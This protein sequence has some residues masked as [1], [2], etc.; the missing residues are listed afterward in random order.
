M[1]LRWLVNQ[2]L[3]DA[4]EG[5]VREV[6]ADIAQSPRTG[7]RVPSPPVSAEAPTAF[8]AP[9]FLP[10]DVVFIFALSIESGGLVDQL[11]EAET[12]RHPHGVE[13]AGKLARHEVAIIESGVGQQAAAQATAEA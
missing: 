6:V 8:E 7:P 11:I 2:F 1:L 3:R 12:S 9:E 5:R 13:R 4:A 10:C